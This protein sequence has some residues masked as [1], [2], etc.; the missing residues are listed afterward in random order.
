M[1]RFI[2]A[3]VIL[4]IFASTIMLGGCSTPSSSTEAQQDL[5]NGVNLQ[6]AG[7]WQEAIDEFTKAIELDPSIE[8]AYI[9]RGN[10]YNE[11]SQYDKAI[12]D[13]NK[14]IELKP[15]DDY[16]Y[17][18]RGS[19]YLEMANLDNSQLDKAITDF[20]KAIEFNPKNT[21]AYESRS[22]AY[23]RKGQYDLADADYKKVLQIS[24][25][26]VRAANLAKELSDLKNIGQPTGFVPAA[27]TTSQN[28]SILTT[29]PLLSPA[30]DLT[31]TWTGSG[32]FYTNNIMGERASKVTAKVVFTLKQTG[33]SVTGGYQIYPISQEPLS[34]ISVPVVGGSGQSLTGTVSITNLTLDAGGIKYGGRGAIEEWKFTF[35]TDLMSG[36]VT[37]MDTDSYTGLD[38][39]AKAV[40][41]VRQ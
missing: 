12:A 14:A 41:L 9:Y 39:D 18:V 20:S 30:R 3:A 32:V 16:P 35:T 7:K 13:E 22:I 38:S 15:K 17:Y 40:N 25:D 19:I 26:S 21:D 28:Q 23:A 11:L 34:D 33:N 1:K 24:N 4:L 10:C 2:F 37:N 29:T 31:G 8:Y 27:P 6:K 5:A 36:G